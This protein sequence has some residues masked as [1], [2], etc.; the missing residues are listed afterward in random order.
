M[1]LARLNLILVAA[2]VLVTLSTGVGLL[3]YS[4]ADDRP[5]N[6]TGA[7]VLKPAGTRVPKIARKPIRQVL[8]EAAKAVQ[9]SQDAASRAYALAELTKAQASAGD[10]E[11]ALASARQAAAAALQIQPELRCGALIT[12]AWAR[13]VAGDRKGALDVLRL[14]MKSTEA[15]KSDEGRLTGQLQWL[16]MSQSD[17]GDR[18]AALATIQKMH[19]LAFQKNQSESQRNSA[20][21]DLVRAQS[22]VGDYDGALESVATAS[23][24]DH[25][26]QGLLFSVMASAVTAVLPDY[27]APQKQLTADDRETRLRVLQKIAKAVEPFEFAEEKPYVDLPISMAVLGDC[28]GA[29]RLAREFGK[30]SIRFPQGI[31]LTAGPF[32]LARIGACQGKAG[33]IGKARETFREA[34]E[35][36]RRDPKLTMRLGQIAG[37][38]AE[39]GD[40]AGALKTAESVGPDE[41]VR[42][43]INIAEKQRAAGD[44][45]GARAT[46]Q[47][48]LG[49]A[50]VLLRD[51][52]RVAD[53]ESRTDAA[54]KKAAASEKTK[55]AQ[56]KSPD[57]LLRRW[58]DLLG[59]TAAVHAKLGDLKAAIE[60]MTLISL[61]DYR[62]WAIRDIA[63]ARARAGDPEGTLEWALTLQP[64]SARVWAL[65][66]LATGALPEPSRM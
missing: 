15:M 5:S 52:P 66:G 49:K 42:T 65:R 14:A 35:L 3:T 1:F 43:Y 61:D 48:A 47:I 37:G 34:L 22:Y 56:P 63:E 45:K 54:S 44:R 39:A 4:G 29:L 60:T 28:E 17:L 32:I 58:D 16:A 24:G 36:V 20:L 64:E 55:S 57:F 26:A 30:G 21:I 38:Q 46:L 13:E 6:N 31:D 51:L 53:A 18:N 62:G 7:Q 40:F 9:S 11:G 23:G 27:L 25:Y 33:Q 8:Q 2:T 19:S 41:S 10:R 12:V 59:Q 50:Q